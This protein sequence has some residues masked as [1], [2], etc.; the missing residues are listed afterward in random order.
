MSFNIGMRINAP[1]FNIG[2]R[3][4]AMS[5][6]IP[7][8]IHKQYS[9]DMIRHDHKFPQPDKWKMIRDVRPTLVGDCTDFGM[10]HDFAADFPE[11]IGAVMNANC[12]EV[13]SRTR[14]IPS[15]VAY[16]VD[17]ILVSE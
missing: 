17:S 6:N 9:V 11:M 2:M 5:F 15:P 7:R 12:N 14:V 4:N 1:S 8:F 13:N 3:I 16:C 10:M